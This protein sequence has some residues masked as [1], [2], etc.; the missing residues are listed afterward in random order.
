MVPGLVSERESRE[1]TP[2]PPPGDHSAGAGP[3]G[4]GLP[5]EARLGA[6]GQ[7]LAE[8]FARVLG[9]LPGAPLRPSAL[10]RT[11]GVD[12][13]LAS[14]L[15]R[16]TAAADALAV[17]HLMPGPEPLRRILRGA[18]RKRVDRRLLESAASAVE[19]F[20]RLIE[21]EAGDRAGLDAMISA[22]LPEAREKH[23]LASKQA[24]FRA[25]TQMR[26]IAAEAHVAAVLL[27]PGA[28]AKGDRAT[29]M[30]DIGLR[31]IRP[32]TRVGFSTVSPKDQ[33]TR[34]WT[35]D[36]EEANDPNALRLPAFC[37][38]PTPEFESVR[39]GEITAYW[40]AGSEAGLKSSVDL[41]MAE[42]RPGVVKP[43]RTEDGRSHAGVFAV[44]DTPCRQGTLDV[45]VHR[46][47]HAG[48][49][50]E[51]LIYD[52]VPRGYVSA[53]GDPAREPDRLDFHESIRP[54]GAGT[55]GARL[56]HVSRYVEMLEH[57]CARL[58]W[59]A[60]AFRGYRLD[61]GYPVYGAQYMIGFKLNDSPG[62]GEGAG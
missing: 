58:G 34:T 20:E 61:I 54:L 53:F 37:S 6:L 38:T 23:E 36:R 28:G 22:F 56:A 9:A 25:N 30:I 3:A 59:E 60:G 18:E 55:A 5:L 40:V 27:H 16:A 57:V 19:G 32:G 12:A 11:L 42:Y 8:G 29:L 21:T 39:E 46:D 10:A 44:Y 15:L 17:V 26:G 1:V 50:P 13:M 31:R 35:L 7:G 33:S 62:P 24:A 49:T 43:H 48:V 14:R 45:F 52:T 47:L 2:E 41:V 51:L 4:G